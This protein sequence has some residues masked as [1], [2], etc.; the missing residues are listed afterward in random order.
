MWCLKLTMPSMKLTM[1]WL[2]LTY[3][4]EVVKDYMIETDY[5]VIETDYV[6]C[7]G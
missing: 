7:G 5:V 1:W 2:K 3:V 6:V 4:D